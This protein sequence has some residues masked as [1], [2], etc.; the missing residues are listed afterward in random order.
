RAARNV[1]GRVILYADHVTGS[2]ARAM[3]ETD[4]RREKQ[5]AWNEANGITPESVRSNIG[6][7]MNSMY[8]KD[9]VTVDSGLAEA[10]S[11]YGH[12]M[13][14]VIEDMTKRMREAA[15]NLEFEE[16]ARLRD[17]V[18]RLE[19]LE[20]TISD[21]PMARMEAGEDG[22]KRRGRRSSAPAPSGKVRKNSLDEMTVGRTE[23]KR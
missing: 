15:A 21:D 8:E 17:E 11:A 2:M 10:G 19:A 13:K 9:R 12:N 6:D 20:L 16:A 4:R 22:G 5:V 1:D 18:K 23:K 3:E 7:T 14:A